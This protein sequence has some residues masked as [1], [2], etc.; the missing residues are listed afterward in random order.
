MLINSSIII[1]NKLSGHAALRDILKKHWINA[2]MLYQQV[3]Y[4]IL[5]AR[6]VTVCATNSN[7][8]VN[9]AAVTPLIVDYNVIYFDMLHQYVVPESGKAHRHQAA[10]YSFN[11]FACEFSV[12][13][14]IVSCW[15]DVSVIDDS[16]PV[17]VTSRLI[18]Y[19]NI[20]V[21]QVNIIHHNTALS[22]Y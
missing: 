6:N 15:R 17:A 20:S 22:A 4:D 9:W 21:R 8:Q 14:K 5:S 13:F 1:N 12:F 3:G 11:N 18:E 10:T 7:S 2:N 19:L 16:F